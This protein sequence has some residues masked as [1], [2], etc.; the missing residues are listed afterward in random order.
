MNMGKRSTKLGK[1][2]ADSEAEPIGEATIVRLIKFWRS[3]RWTDE[4]IL[5][6]SGKSIAW[7]RETDCLLKLDE[8]TFEAFCSS[9][10]NRSVAIKLA[11]VPD[12]ND[13]LKRLHRARELAAQRIKAL[14]ERVREED[15]E[16]QH[17]DLNG[18]AS[19]NG[20]ESTQSH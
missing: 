14:L 12:T 13:R 1:Q 20:V 3:E 15:A 9:E 2:L 10:I 4:A 18:R 17:H 16:R 8:H 7:L 5:R 19:V 11:E 6:A